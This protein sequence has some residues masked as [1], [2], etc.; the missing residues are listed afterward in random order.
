LPRRRCGGSTGT[1]GRCHPGDDGVADRAAGFVSLSARG[2][3]GAMTKNCIGSADTRRTGPIVALLAANTEK[4]SAGR[5]ESG[6]DGYGSAVHRRQLAGHPHRPFPIHSQVARR[7]AD[8]RP[9]P[10]T[11]QRSRTGWPY[12]LGRGSP[13]AVGRSC[14]PPSRHR[15]ARPTGNDLGRGH[16]WAAVTDSR[17]GPWF[18]RAA[19][20]AAHGQRSWRPVRRRGRGRNGRRRPR[21]GP[22]SA[23]RACAGFGRYGCVRSP[24]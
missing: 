9:G 24:R 22:G 8:D 3:N 6:G 13:Q 18:P 2:V 14:Q 21:A 15:E 11:S 7:I 4:S 10:P 20:V 19:V 17:G 23:P 5:E 1:H 16:P 12:C